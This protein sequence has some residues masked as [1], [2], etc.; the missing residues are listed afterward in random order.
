MAKSSKRRSNKKSQALLQIKNKLRGT[1][2]PLRTLSEIRENASVHS[3]SDIA[4]WIRSH[5]YFRDVWIRSE[6]PKSVA[7]LEPGPLLMPLDAA[8]EFR[9]AGAR[10]IPH[11]NKLNQFV[12]LTK[13]FDR[14]FLSGANAEAADTLNLL[15][16]T[17]GQSQWLTKTRIALLQL[18]SGLDSHKRYVSS[19]LREIPQGVFPFITYFVS[20]RNEPAVSPQRFQS[21]FKTE[22]TKRDLSPAM[23]GYIRMH[24]LPMNHLSESQIGQILHFATTSAIVDLYETFLTMSYYAVEGRMLHLYFAIE[25]VLLRLQQEVKDPRLSL[26]KLEITRP[27]ESEEPLQAPAVSALEHFLRGDMN[28]AQAEVDRLLQES[29]DCFDLWEVAARSAAVSGVQSPGTS[30]TFRAGLVQRMKSVIIKSRTINEDINELIK[31]CLNFNHCGWTASVL[32][33]IT[34]EVSPFSVRS[35]HN[36]IYR[37]A[38][39]N[40]YISPTRVHELERP[41][42]EKYLG[43]LRSSGTTGLIAGYMNAS[44]GV[45]DAESLR[46]LSREEGLVLE[47]EAALRTANIKECLKVAYDLDG[48]PI[49]Y[50]Q[51]KAKRLIAHS[52]LEL[53]ELDSCLEFICETFMRDHNLH[54]VLPIEETIETIEEAVKQKRRKR[55]GASIAMP[56]LYDMYSRYIGHKYDAERSYAYE[57]FLNCNGMQRPSELNQSTENWPRDR[58]VYYLRYLCVEPVMHRSITFSRSK[59]I[60]EER[61]RVCRLLMEVD[62]QNIEFYQTEIRDTLQQLMIQKRIRQVEQSK[63]YVD[64]EGLRAAVTKKL[65]ESFNRYVAF[66]KEGL[67]K[68]LLVVQKVLDELTARGQQK[69]IIFR[70]PDNEMQDIF[71]HLLTDLRDEFISSPEYGLDKYLSVRIRHGTFSGELRKPL[72]THNLITQRDH[73]SGQYRPNEYWKDRLGIEDYDPTRSIVDERFASFSQQVDDYIKYMLSNWVQIKKEPSDIGLLDFSLSELFMS[74]MASW[75]RPETTFEQFLEF[76]FEEFN[77]L[78]EASLADI[79][80]RI[81]SE[82]KVKVNGMLM[83]LQNGFESY[84]FASLDITDLSNN[85]R[86]AGTEMQTAFNRVGDWFK[87]SKTESNEPFFVEDAIEISR[88]TLSTSYRDLNVVINTV[89]RAERF[90]IP[91]RYLTNF[92]DIF[93]NIFQNM[94]RHSGIHSL[95]GSVTITYNPSLLTLRVENPIAHGLALPATRT[96][97]RNTK[98]AMQEAGRGQ[99]F[100]AT[101]GGTG[102]YKIWR[103]L[104]NDFKNASPIMDFDF[105]GTDRFFVEF[106]VNIKELT[107]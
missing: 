2:A 32:N 5:P 80:A 49:P 85:I 81:E 68:S 93:I 95:T 44:V 107:A 75:I 106:G 11:A 34:A 9:W 57:D 26:L 38:L 23:E 78:L 31:V 66:Q 86:A 61:V 7:Q 82:A 72:E 55:A 70:V 48:S 4:E 22:L 62:N 100:I 20:V 64:I 67:D 74:R 76:L 94:L 29:P 103:I 19:L 45:T 54:F 46:Q 12:S 90:D 39:N 28:E 30:E 43:L 40:R 87:L 15:E 99:R 77:V 104:F 14:Y 59:E 89:T 24:V 102:L 60:S 98:N 3:Y 50:Y 79:R 73:N 17:L 83:A 6:F 1:D 105:L 58:V 84:H 69:L 96:Q 63:I 27:L 42:Q 71:T 35:A 101:E 18:T 88:G 16:A 10:L 47:A 33:L 53:D 21:Q 56:I 51:H 36:R 41:L 65:S 8:R 97:L 25:P 37:A 52:L 13:A 91:G 92:V